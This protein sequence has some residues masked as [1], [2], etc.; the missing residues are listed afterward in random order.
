MNL[1]KKGAEESNVI[2]FIIL[3]LVVAGLVIWFSYGFFSRGSDI[4]D[5]TDPVVQSA[6]QSCKAELSINSGAWCT[7]IKYVPYAK[8]KQYM[9]CDYLNARTGSTIEGA[10][11]C[12]ADSVT[13]VLGGYCVELNRTAGSFEELINGKVCKK[14]SNGLKFDNKV[15]WDA[16]KGVWS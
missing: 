12:T 2:I 5:A 1:R 10:P 7:S 11:N 9:T 4:L 8:S 13:K 14:D 3:A 15:T 16:E 6:L